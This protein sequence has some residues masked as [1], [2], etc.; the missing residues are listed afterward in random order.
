MKHKSSTNHLIDES[1]PYLLM[2]KGTVENKFQFKIQNKKKPR[3]DT[4]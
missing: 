2:E 4:G 1:S 3:A